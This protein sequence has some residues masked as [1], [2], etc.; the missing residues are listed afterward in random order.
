MTG[1]APAAAHSSSNKCFCIGVQPVPPYS[2]GQPGAI[3]PFE[4]NLRC[5][6]SWSSL[7]KRK[8][9]MVLRQTSSGTS[10]DTKALTSARKFS[11]SEV[12]TNS[13]LYSRLY[14]FDN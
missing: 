6:F 8:P 11:S 2:T 13:I 5:Q 9:V 14:D 12:S 3:H 1:G 10:F 4:Y 7:L